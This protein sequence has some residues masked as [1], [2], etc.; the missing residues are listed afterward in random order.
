LGA[1]ALGSLIRGSD[2]RRT[3][4]VDSETRAFVVLPETRV[5]LVPSETRIQKLFE[6]S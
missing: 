3:Y 5:K 1:T 2:P 6:E 4:F